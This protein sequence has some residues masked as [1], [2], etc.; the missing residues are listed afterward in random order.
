MIKFYFTIFFSYSLPN[1]F[2]GI[3]RNKNL[4]YSVSSYNNFKATVA[5][6][7]SVGV[8]MKSIFYNDTHFGYICE[9]ALESGEVVNELNVYNL[10]GFKCV[11]KE[12][13]NS[14]EYVSLLENNEILLKNENEIALYNLQGIEKFNYKFDE[15]VYDVISTTASKRY[16]I[17][18]KELEYVILKER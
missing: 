11:S 7:I 6:D 12:V 10:Y 2:A 8:E 14:Y 9:K 18:Q 16:Y 15:T 17:I 13:S 1:S 3:I 4:F 5:K